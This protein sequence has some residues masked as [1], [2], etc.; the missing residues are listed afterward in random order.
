M[1]QVDEKENKEMN[2]MIAECG[3]L[4]KYLE[5]QKEIIQQRPEEKMLILSEMITEYQT[6]LLR[7]EEIFIERDARKYLEIRRARYAIRHGLEKVV[8]IDILYDWLVE[9]VC[10]L[11]VD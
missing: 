9:N 11:E 7:L 6:V 4:L 10:N 1:R 5:K 2:I 8:A 3:A